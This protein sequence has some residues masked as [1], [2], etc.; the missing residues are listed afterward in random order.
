MSQHCS[1][2]GSSGENRAMV[3]ALIA[4]YGRGG[5]GGY[6]GQMLRMELGPNPRNP[7]DKI[8]IAMIYTKLGDKDKALSYLERA[9][10][11]H[12]GDMIFINVEPSFEPIRREPRLP[13]L[14]RKVG[15][16]GA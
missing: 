2:S 10:A 15:I 13:A 14:A 6:W 1:Q 12:A 11:E 9:Y 16:P 7:K 8:R 3:D 5:V 4:E